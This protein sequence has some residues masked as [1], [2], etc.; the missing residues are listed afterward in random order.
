MKRN[1]NKRPLA[2][3]TGFAA[4]LLAVIF[5]LAGCEEIGPEWTPQ[6]AIGDPGPG[7]GTIFYVSKAGFEVAGK[8]ICHYLEAAP[9]NLKGPGA[10]GSMEGADMASNNWVTG[11]GNSGISISG[12][13]GTAIGTGKA[14]TAAIIA[15][16]GENAV[17]QKACDD[18]ENGG[19][20]DWFMPSKDELNALYQQ[21][22]KLSDLARNYW[23][24]TQAEVANQVWVQNFSDTGEQKVEPKGREYATRPIRAF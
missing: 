3:L 18:Y 17:N 8:G 7:G 24:S 2:S 22:D 19:R 11:V 12:A 21:K 13:T 16:L 10:G 23:S 15:A 14:N 20:D 5:T 4:L 6:Y 9:K 1:G